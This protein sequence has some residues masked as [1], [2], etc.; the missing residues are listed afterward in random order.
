MIF[1]VPFNTGYSVIKTKE[2]EWYI[3]GTENQIR[4]P[5]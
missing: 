5:Q 1:V 2:D 4:G 3:R